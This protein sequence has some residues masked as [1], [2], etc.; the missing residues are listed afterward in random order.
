MCRKTTTRSSSPND[1]TSRFRIDHPALGAQGPISR[2]PGQDDVARIGI[3][4]D[5][6][7]P[8]QSGKKLHGFGERATGGQAHLDCFF[9]P[10][11]RDHA[12]LRRTADVFLRILRGTGQTQDSKAIAP[13]PYSSTAAAVLAVRREPRC[14]IP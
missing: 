5:V 7:N 14:G 2:R 1:R 3:E 10:Q 4:K 13:V 8:H 12:E 6:L 9:Q 11:K